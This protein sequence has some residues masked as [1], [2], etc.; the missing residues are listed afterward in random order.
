MNVLVACEFSGTVRDAF[1]RRGHNAWS[2]DLVAAPGR[3]IRGDIFD[4]INQ[5]T[6]WELDLIIAHPP[7]TYLSAAGLHYCKNDLGR[8]DKRDRAV[9]FVK[10]LFNAP[11]NR[12]AI[13][14]P[15]GYLSTAWRKPDQIVRMCDFGHAEA[16]K[17]TCL[18]LKGLPKLVPTKV[19]EPRHAGGRSRESEWYSKTKCK[20]KRSITFAGFAEAMAEQW[21][22]T[23]AQERGT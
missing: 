4:V 6:P 15:V 10:K 9:E 1:L 14:N 21:G 3:H 20:I 17:P 8:Q 16:I 11:A 13:E 5:Y 7:C 18:W 23:P 19:V 22:L 2:C 12:I